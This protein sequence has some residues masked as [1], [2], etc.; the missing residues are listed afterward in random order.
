MKDVQ[1]EERT[2][3]EIS[4]TPNITVTIRGQLR[5]YYAYVTTAGPDFDGPT[6][7]TLF[8]YQE[9][10]LAIGLLLELGQGFNLKFTPDNHVRVPAIRPADVDA[11]VLE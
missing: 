9:S 11:G 6:T 7:M 3:R 2:M 4:P 1:R 5:V 8:P 10:D